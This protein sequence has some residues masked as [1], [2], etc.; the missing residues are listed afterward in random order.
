[1]RN[2]IVITELIWQE[3]I[4]I[5]SNVGEVM[6]DPELWKKDNLHNI[7]SKATALI[8]RNQTQVNESLINNA[9]NLKVIG[10][11]GVGLDNIDLESAK[12]R[13]IS[14]VFAKNANA[15]SVTE[16]VLSAILSFSRKMDLATFDVKRGNWNRKKFTLHEAYNKT[17]GLIGIGEISSRLASRAKSL[18]MNIIGYDPFVA[19]YEFA[20]SDIGVQLKS[21][22]EVLSMS[23]F[24]S[25]HVPLNESTR[26]MI[27]KDSFS[28]MKPSSYII[29]TSRGGIIKENDLNEALSSGLISGAALDVFE[30]EP[31]YGSPLLNQENVILTPHIAGLTEE[32]QVRT[33]CLVAT[34]VANILQGAPSTCLAC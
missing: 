29:N 21:Y 1:M 19:P 2:S 13:N 14:V 5:L 3:G 18:G 10:R 32:A 25:I 30:H 7:V 4:D 24:I 15:T 12:K 22:E 17:L 26:Y 34:E 6:Y 27:N 33:S 8:V 9:D 16:Y 23:D 28:K 31:P 20:I 11:L